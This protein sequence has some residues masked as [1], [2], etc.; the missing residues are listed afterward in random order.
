M[1]GI[2]DDDLSAM[3]EQLKPEM[4]SRVTVAK[5]ERLFST[6]DVTRGFF[7]LE[8]GLVRLTRHSVDG[9]E[10]TLHVARP[11][12]TFAEASLFA[13]CYRCDAVADLPSTALVV[14]KAR[15]LDA[16][17]SDSEVARRWIAHLSRQVQRRE[18]R[19]RSEG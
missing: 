19:L 18:P 16:L 15:M 6:D 7:R 12:E 10:V 8:M 9:N 13:E 17:V 3:F 5:G 11:G 1:P 4:T 14:D 2:V